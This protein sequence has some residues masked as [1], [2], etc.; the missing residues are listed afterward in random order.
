[1]GVELTGSGSVPHATARPSTG[2]CAILGTTEAGESALKALRA[3]SGYGATETAR[4]AEIDTQLVALKSGSPKAMLA[5]L[6][7]AR[8]D[9]TTLAAK[10]KILGETF[11]SDRASSRS[12]LCK[13]AKD[14]ADDANRLG[15]D[16]FKRAFFNA[17]GSPEWQAFSK[18]AHALARKESTSY[19]SA[20]DR[21][22]FCEQPLDAK[23]RQHITALLSFVEGHAQRRAASASKTV[24]AEIKALQ[25]L[26][27]EPFS[28]ES[29]VREHVHRLDPAVESAVVDAVSTVHHHRKQ[30]IEA[31]R[32]HGSVGGAVEM[33]GV[34]Q[35]VDD[36]QTRIHGDVARLQEG[37]AT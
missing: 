24:E 25:D 7:Q 34:I 17:V 31:L 16:Q 9:I 13:E 18:A 11:T 5:T 35:I 2:S 6:V 27:V 8:A 15:I 12:K 30:T 26:D 22:L 33:K 23:S 4:L 29:R 19:P 20:E 1:V 21:C 14:S 28:A 10:L 36:L 32:S 37:D 3:L